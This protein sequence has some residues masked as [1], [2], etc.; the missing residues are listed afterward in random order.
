MRPLKTDRE[1]SPSSRDH[2]K[3]GFALSALE[4]LVND[5]QGQPEWRERS[6][7]ACAYYDMG[8]Q[9]SARREQQ[10]RMDMGIEPRQTNLVHG[11]INGV[12]G[13]EAKARSDVRIEADDEE[14]AD[15]A[16]VLSKAMKEA[17]REANTDMAIS[18]G[19]ASQVKAGIGWV[20]VSRANDPLDYPYRVADVH[21]NEIWYDWRARNLGLD[22]ARWLVRKRWEDLDE[23]KAL[24][25]EFAD[26][27]EQSVNGWDM[28][29]LPDDQQSLLYRSYSNERTTRISRD[30]W[31]DSTRRRIKF[32]EVWYRVP[33][34]VVVIH[35]S[36]TRRV[37]YDENSRVHQMALASGKVKV[38]RAITRQVRMALFAGPHRL[39]DV[40]TTRRFFPYIPFFAFRDDEDR[41][42]YGLIEGMISPQDEYNERRQMIN[43]MLKA[44]QVYIDSD[45]LDTEYNTVE[46]VAGSAMRPDMVAVLNPHRK[47]A[48]GFVIKNDLTLQKEQVDVMQDSKA[49]IQEVPRIYSTQLGS[50]PAGVTSGIANSLLIEQGAVAMGELNDNYRYGRKRVH[51][52]LLDL[53]C[54]D[55][56]EADMEVTLGAGQNRRVVVLNTWDPKTEQPLNHVKDAP[57]KVGLSDVPTSPAFRMQEQQQIATMIQ[58][59]GQNPQAMAILAPAYLEGSSLSNRQG[60]A[61]DLRRVMGVPVAGDRQAQEQQQAAL[62]EQQAQQAALAQQAAQ[63]QM[64]SAAADAENR[65][66]QARL[67][68]AKAAEIE[69]NL[70]SGIAVTQGMADIDKTASET[71]LNAARIRQIGEQID[72]ALRQ[73]TVDDD[74]SRINEALAD[75]TA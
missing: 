75:A 27:L 12:L 25:P 73:E 20:E 33:A 8:K 63:L 24:M 46:D 14:S 15:V 40:G 44:R 69:Q 53:I 50:A 66:A 57:I 42:P 5:C 58:A 37:V 1:G 59:L 17:Q 38:S 54:E 71:Q 30:E 36:P 62:Q 13:Q 2:A 28:L 49:L 55:H 21:R 39:I 61:D 51:E 41:S 4:D 72:Q 34:E 48:N 22:D 74:E 32:F 43:W 26:I 68:T 67:T 9:L 45:A 52:A 35:L 64:Q 11:V 16:D 70:Q 3:K 19:Y 65:G 10:I 29:S 23:S 18:N 6:D 60:M 47:N 7:K 56:L 31:A